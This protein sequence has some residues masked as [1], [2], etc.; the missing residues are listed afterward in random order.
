MNTK[1]EMKRVTVYLSPE[2][3]KTLKSKLVMLEE[4]V[5]GWFRK[6]ITKFLKENK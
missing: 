3:H 4:T 6:Q 2:E 1:N 5:S